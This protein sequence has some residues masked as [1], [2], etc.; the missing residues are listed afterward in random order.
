MKASFWVWFTLFFSSVTLQA[1]QRCGSFDYVKQALQHDP[2]LKSRIQ[3]TSARLV[4]GTGSTINARP[5]TSVIKIPIVVHVI[6]HLP[7]ENISDEAIQKQ[8]A[9]LNRDYR[10]MNADSINTPS[11]FQDVAADTGIEF[12]LAK[13]T[14]DGQATN[15][16]ERIYSPVA[17]WSSDDKV[18][19][20]KEYGAN[21]WDADSYLNIW[22]CSM[23][24]LLGYASILG[25]AKQVDGV[26]I[27]YTVF[28]DVEDGGAY[29]S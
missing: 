9:A 8:L 11:Y 26:V 20:K 27:D 19:Y 16:I 22:V 29:N 2:T 25:E 28:N 18:K 3:N 14:P 4:Q 13:A 12:E 24:D 6:Y 23:N 17:K 5:S 15:G 10:R 1:Q 21:A 7:Q